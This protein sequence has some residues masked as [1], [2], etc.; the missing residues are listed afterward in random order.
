MLLPS[1][2]S[3]D[4]LHG[5]EATAVPASSDTL[6]LGKILLRHPCLILRAALS[7]EI[8]FQG[9]AAS[10]SALMMSWITRQPP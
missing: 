9:L 7:V 8:N 4:R 6:M 3:L 1:V 10:C 2:S 5:D